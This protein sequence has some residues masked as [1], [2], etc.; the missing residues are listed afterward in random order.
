M[1][2][3]LTPNS[4]IQVGDSSC[5]IMK[6]LSIGSSCV[7][8]LV[9]LKGGS[10]GVLKEFAPN[11]FK[12]FYVRDI[13]NNLILESD[14]T[15]VI[16]QHEEEKAV[17][18]QEISALLKLNQTNNHP[19][20]FSC[21]EHDKEAGRILFYT[22]SGMTF[23]QWHDQYEHM[24]ADDEREKT[25]YIL[26]SV[27]LIRKLLTVLESV[28]QRLLHCDIK[29]DN[30]FII[31]EDASPEKLVS[32]SFS[33]TIAIL[34]F[35]SAK[36]I[37]D[38]Q[39]AA[40]KEDITPEE[41]DRIFA[42]SHT[43]RYAHPAL[44]GIQRHCGTS[45]AMQKEYAKLIDERVDWY[46]SGRVLAYLLNE[47][48]TG[49]LNH[50]F[51]C[52]KL[53]RTLEVISRAIG[54]AISPK[55]GL[56]AKDIVGEMNMLLK[57]AERALKN[58]TG[59]YELYLK[60]RSFELSRS[61]SVYP[62]LLSGISDGSM[63]FDNLSAWYEQSDKKAVRVACLADSGGSGKTSQMVNLFRCSQNNSHTITL[64]V[65]LVD[66]QNEGFLSYICRTYAHCEDQ[67][68]ALIQLIKSDRTN[69]YLF[70]LDG[71]NE[72][73]A[74][75]KKKIE[76]DDLAL[77]H[78][79]H[80]DIIITSREEISRRFACAYKTIYVLPLT[81]RQIVSY[82]GNKNL[83][84]RMMNILKNPMNACLYTQADY[85]Y[86][87]KRISSWKNDCSAAI[88]ASFVEAQLIKL[89]D[90]IE[91]IIE[92][93]A[94]MEELAYIA[95]K[96]RYTDR[97]PNSKI[98]I[99]TASTARA[100]GILKTQDFGFTY[101]FAHERW[102][103][104]YTGKYVVNL[105]H[106]CLNH[107]REKEISFNELNDTYYSWE[108]LA[109]AGELLEDHL[110]VPELDKEAYVCRVPMN[111]SLLD[112][113]LSFLRKNSDSYEEKYITSNIVR[114]MKYARNKDLSL[115]DFSS[116]NLLHTNLQNLIFSRK[117]RGKNRLCT[118]FKNAQIGSG[119]FLDSR[120]TIYYGSWDDYL[121]GLNEISPCRYELVVKHFSEFTDCSIIPLTGNFSEIK[122]I[123]QENSAIIYVLDSTRYSEKIHIFILN[124]NGQLTKMDEQ[125]ADF[126][127]KKEND[128]EIEF[129]QRP[130]MVFIDDKL[131]LSYYP[132]QTNPIHLE[133]GQIWGDQWNLCQ[134]AVYSNSIG[135][136]I[137]QNEYALHLSKKNITDRDEYSKNRIPS[138]YLL[139]N[140]ETLFAEVVPSMRTIIAGPRSQELSVLNNADKFDD[141]FS[142]P[143]KGIVRIWQFNLGLDKLLSEFEIDAL[144]Y[145]FSCCWTDKRLLLSDESCA[146]EY[147][148]NGKLVRRHIHQSTFLTK[149]FDFSYISD[150]F[151]NEKII[152]ERQIVD[153]TTLVV[154]DDQEAKNYTYLG[155]PKTYFYEPLLS[156]PDWF[157]DTNINDWHC[158]CF[159]SFSLKNF[160]LECEIH[161]TRS[162]SK[163]Q[164]DVKVVS[165]YRTQLN[166][167]KH[168]LRHDLSIDEKLCFLNIQ[169]CSFEKARIVGS[170]EEVE[171][172]RDILKYNCA[173]LE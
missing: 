27:I 23:T 147:D 155:K 110:R 1:Y 14:N 79:K 43:P 69:R 104:F 47:K 169:Q 48:I 124:E 30:L 12:N 10:F 168:I 66:L 118:S 98:K 157:P 89:F 54:A 163:E 2:S 74:I 126:I 146:V 112:D 166:M 71:Y 95:A 140:D 25:H 40:E 99:E 15:F 144:N 39:H 42:I 139:N 161:I 150:Y 61:F 73:T 84:S 80:V 114:M 119:C 50:L 9:Q 49:K 37:L 149:P 26:A 129:L 76:E 29:P 65:P 6:K 67:R 62:E 82:I 143:T 117:V 107:G 24:L 136:F 165:L 109:F 173:Q 11:W 170:K 19:N 93:R 55:R 108:A 94:Q 88:M 21:L 68:D 131:H 17:F 38:L 41:L 100:T 135:R 92:A 164:K 102:L 145:P 35:G 81:T 34:D 106:N 44:M 13:N 111:P 122:V 138:I 70:L 113:M 162:Y 87:Q 31:A 125:K 7:T 3:E 51:G 59:L 167:L 97:I 45:F 115:A 152:F 63:F 75:Q 128:E 172:M 20:I 132:Y 46:S 121:I 116:L 156:I 5:Q 101:Q 105:I 16:R 28:H 154:I 141:I 64:Y 83:S 22:Q 153:D 123:E 85:I 96:Y 142:I 90:D 137:D 133:T 148:R 36:S 33:S 77:S 32:S 127:W 18:N 130:Q 78:Q 134:S 58:E 72:T 160:R 86:N 57:Q 103:N 8:Y 120:K 53:D 4:C 56:G 52:D 60:E 91:K 171:W 151:L 158:D 159:I